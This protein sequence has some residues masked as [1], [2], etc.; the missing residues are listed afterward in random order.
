MRHIVQCAAPVGG[1]V[2][3]PF[4]GSGTT[5]LVAKECQRR[6]IGIEIQEEYCEIAVR[7]LAQDLLPLEEPLIARHDR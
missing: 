5:L 4:M 7:R 1:V 6:A 3:D 2:V